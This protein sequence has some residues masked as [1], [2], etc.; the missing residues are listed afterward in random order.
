MSSS[1]SSVRSFLVRGLVTD[2]SA[3][4]MMLGGIDG[5]RVEENG[6]NDGDMGTSG[7]YVR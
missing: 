2:G 5:V 6:G 1:S 3:V 4:L 7:T